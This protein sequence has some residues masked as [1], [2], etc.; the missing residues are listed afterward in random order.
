MPQ[1]EF[2]VV[3]V[4]H[5]DLAWKRGRAEMS[6]MLEIVIVRLLDALERYPDFK[7]HLEQAAHFRELARRRPDLVARLRPYIEAGRI[8]VV[9]GMA[10]TLETN[11]PNGEC[12]VRNQQM[13]LQWVRQNWGIEVKTGWLVDTFGVHAQVPQVMRSFGISQ[14]VANRLG[15]DHTR[16]LFV[17][18]GLDGSEITVA[19]WGTYAGYIQPENVSCGFCRNWDDI[20]RC[21]LHA[22]TLTGAGPF[23]VVVGTENEMLVS[24]YP[25]T[26]IEQQNDEHPNQT[27][28]MAVP[29]E[30]FAA[31][32]KTG[33]ALPVVDGDLNPEFT[34][35]FSLRHSIRL[36]N[37]AVENRLLEAD[38][39]AA[40]AGIGKSASAL[41]EAWWQLAYIHFHDVFTGSHPTVIFDDV[42]RILDE[43]EEVANSVLHQAF[44][45]L[46]PPSL[47]PS[48]AQKSDTCSVVAFNG[49]PWTRCDTLELPLPPDFDGVSR[50]RDAGGALIPFEVQDGMVRA[51]V[52]VPAV[53]FQLYS[54]EPGPAQAGEWKEAETGTLE[55][56][57]IRFEVDRVTGIARL[58]WKPTGA[59]LLEN[60]GGWLAAQCD[61][62]NFQIENPNGAE[63]TAASGSLRLELPLSPSPFRQTARLSGEFPPLSWAGAGNF[64]RW[65]AEFSL[66]ADRP[67]VRLDLRLDWKG[68]ASRLRLTLPTTLDTSAGIY[69][70]PFGVVRRKPYSPRTNAKGEWPAHRFVAL[71]SDGHGIALVNTGVGGV[72]ANGGTLFTTLL[73]APKGEYAGMIPDATSSQHGRHEYRFSLVPYAGSWAEAGVAQFAQELNNPLLAEVRSDIAA[74]P[75]QASLLR[76]EPSQVVLSCI[77]AASDGSE[78]LIVRVYETAGRKADAILTL[79]TVQRLWACD[80]QENVAEEIPGAGG[81]WRFVINPFEIKTFRAL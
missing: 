81:E 48:P 5:V 46:A 64:L 40:L 28:R 45:R 54:L 47:T 26:L 58:E 43:I 7:Y 29:N 30:Y 41:E 11:L 55:N 10:S 6:E 13:G 76:L 9:G 79:P 4:T 65:E 33:R 49:L 24:L 61:N 75:S 53:G 37:R 34:G 59:V 63:V 23:L 15:G 67:E 3:G 21:F 12:F 77:K 44:A 20:D 25:R 62:G 27:W 57:W 69:E 1:T 68:E 52:E 18:R 70:V 78:Q 50:V 80:L 60:A 51:F 73:R 14:L 19:G 22:E 72:E 31:I 66:Y 35:C 32:E 74:E 71:E 8:E 38:K 17:A 36:R 16:D 42:M 39:W 2:F 56:A